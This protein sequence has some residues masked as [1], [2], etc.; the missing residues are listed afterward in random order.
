MRHKVLKSLAFLVLLSLTSIVL[1]EA[2][3]DTAFETG[4]FANMISS[5][6]TYPAYPKNDMRHYLSEEE[7]HVLRPG[8]HMDFTADDITIANNGTVTVD[9]FISDDAGVPL[10]ITGLETGGEVSISWLFGFIPQ[11]GDQYVSYINRT[12]TSPITGDSAVQPTSES[13][14]TYDELAPGTYRYTLV[15]MLPNNADGNA[16]HSIGVYAR[17]DMREFDLGRF[18]D[19]IVVSFTPNGSA[20]K[21]TA[22]P[23]PRVITTTPQCN[24]CHDPLAIHGGS[25]RDVDLCIM[26]HT[27][28]VIDPDTGNTVDMKVMIHKIHRGA[29]LPSVEDGTPYQIIGYRQSV[30]DYSTVHFPMDIRNCESCHVG[31]AIPPYPNDAAGKKLP[32][33]YAD[34]PDFP[35]WSTN[36]ARE[37]CGS[38]H[39]DIVWATGENHVGGPQASDEFCSGCH[40]PQGD[41]E[42]DASVINAHIIPFN[43]TQLAGM[44]LE[45]INVF[46]AVAGGTPTVRYSFTNDAGEAIDPTETSTF[47][48]IIAGPNEDYDFLARENAAA[49]SVPVAGKG[50]G[51]YDYKMETPLPGNANGESYTAGMEA[52]R[53]VTLNAG[54]ST[55]FNTNESAENVPFYFGVGNVKGDV[56]PR[57]MAVADEQCEECHYNLNLHGS[58]RH[59]TQY[60]I[61]CHQPEASDIARRPESELPPESIDFRRMIHRIHMGEELDRDSYIIYGYG[62]SVHEFAEVRFPGDRANCAKCH[63]DDAYQVQSPAILEVTATENEVFSPLPPDTAACTG[64]HD[65][66]ITFSHAFINIAPFAESCQTCHGPGAEFE[67]DEVHAREG[68]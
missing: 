26:C 4:S 43:S 45:V 40:I 18:T 54:L 51:V 35:S 6:V 39:D 23:P 44:N 12:Q 33:V 63:T 16:A 49:G 46:G 2:R 36:P 10:D 37:Q 47:A 32:L 61:T 30:H 3:V 7:K 59:N 66:E 56:I 5:D 65:D 31:D 68:N 20:N 67:V 62:G 50:M 9:F 58:I 14:G 19:N 11:D 38:C 34:K 29:S 64:C 57:R 27:D 22:I 52:R 15:T 24:N 42:F 1:A 60:C 48:V 8:F 25:R 41:F 55:E 28:E 21:V 17:R 53:S 13:D